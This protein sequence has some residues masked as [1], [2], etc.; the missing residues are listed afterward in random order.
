MF[1]RNRNKGQDPTVTYNATWNQHVACL[2]EKQQ[3]R[4]N[5]NTTAVNLNANNKV[6]E[7]YEER[8]VH[9]QV[10]ILN[11]LNEQNALTEEKKELKEHTEQLRIKLTASEKESSRLN[12]QL[13]NERKSWRVEKTNL[14]KQIFHLERAVD[15]KR[16]EKFREL[17]EQHAKEMESKNAEIWEL[18]KE[19]N[20]KAD[21]AAAKQDRLTELQEQQIRVKDSEI[22]ELGNEL[23]MKDQKIQELKADLA[24]VKQ[25]FADR[26]TELQEQHAKEVESKNA[27]I[28]KLRKELT[29]QHSKELQDQETQGLQA[30]LAAAKQDRLTELQEQQIR[31]KDSEIQE[32]RKDLTE[33]HATELNLKDRKIQ[34]L[35]TDLFAARLTELKEHQELYSKYLEIQILEQSGDRQAPED[36]IQK[37][38]EPADEPTQLHI[39]LGKLYV[40]L[41][42]AKKPQDALMA[43]L[44]RKDKEIEYL[45]KKLAAMNSEVQRSTEMNQDEKNQNSEDKF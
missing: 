17:Q 3:L 19:L 5:L 11:I 45:T 35:K 9:G 4:A 44:T 31:V 26:L 39:E 20:L 13:E 30:D 14:L 1:V 22:Q 41:Q 38:Q 43:Q 27:E 37:L 29:E 18:E 28:Q 15:K 42:E 25:Q 21:L 34:D 40:E 16:S 2:K 36:R 23:Y 32:L 8:I 6:I 7:K 12:N 33:Q 24:A 10:T